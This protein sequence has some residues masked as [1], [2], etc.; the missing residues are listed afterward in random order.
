MKKTTLAQI[1]IFT[2]AAFTSLSSFAGGTTTDGNANESGTGTTAV[3][4]DAAPESMAT[5]SMATEGSTNLSD[6]DNGEDNDYG[7]VGLLGLLGLAGLLKKDRFDST[8]T[9]TR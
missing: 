3:T 2:F 6:A 8:R 7:W 9:Q 1:I 5:E 4:P